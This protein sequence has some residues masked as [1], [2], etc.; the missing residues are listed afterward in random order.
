MNEWMSD[1]LC[2]RIPDWGARER[3]A[4]ARGGDWSELQAVCSGCGVR[5]ECLERG[6]SLMDG[7]GETVLYGGCTPDVMRALRRRRMRRGAAA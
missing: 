2:A 5:V 3:D 4:E 1:A 7:T 6:L